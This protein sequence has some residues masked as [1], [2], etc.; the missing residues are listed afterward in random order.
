MLSGLGLDGV[1]GAAETALYT[2]DSPWADYWRQ[3]ITE[4]RPRLLSSG[5]LD[6]RSIDAFMSRCQDPAWWTQTIAFTV[7]YGRVAQ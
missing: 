7:A 2:G 1:E 5:K 3:T 4:L 6:S